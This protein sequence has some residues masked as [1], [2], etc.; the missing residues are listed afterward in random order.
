MLYW[1]GENYQHLWGPL[2]L[3]NSH[4]VLCSIGG[5]LSALGTFWILRTK[6]QF[7]P[8][9]RGREHAAE[10]QKSVGKPTGAGVLFIPVLLLVCLLVVPWDPYRGV[11]L[12]AV[13]CAMLA[14][15][16]DDR[17]ENSWGR[18]R[19]G[20]LDFVI[21]AVVSWAMLRGQSNIE[22]W[23]P[24][25]APKMGME[26]ALDGTMGMLAP[27]M[28]PKW[29]YFIGATFLL[30]LA[31]NTTNCSDGV[32]GLSGSLLAIAFLPLGGVLYGVVGHVEA[33]RYLLVPFYEMAANWAV[34]VSVTLGTLAS[35][36]WFNAHPSSLLMGDTG[37]RSL[38]LLL[39]IFVLATGNPALI[40]VVAPLI[41]ANGGTGLVK[42]T[43][44]KLFSW[45]NFIKV[46]C[47]LHDHC[48]K[49]LHWSPTQVLIRL[50]LIQAVLG[51]ILIV[52]V[53]KI[54]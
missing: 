40:L 54:R 9:D 46:T 8:T 13:L 26:A 19:K 24:I 11:I 18:F 36:L 43:L 29:F 10:G 1:L 27:I 21:C 20:L 23:W 25:Y 38:G 52:L 51:P 31:I 33:S 14:G 30:W 53:L 49:N 34:V 35:Y 45:R 12:I 16:L 2:R 47:P 39:G 37:S 41:L 32:D 15:F 28:I 22:I 17:S 48:L 5:L 4:L 50:V 44:I 7:L 42:I 6:K 3:L